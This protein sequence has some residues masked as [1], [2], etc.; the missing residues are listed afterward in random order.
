MV[1]VVLRVYCSFYSF[2]SVGPLYVVV[3]F[4]E[5]GSLVEYLRQNR[6]NKFGLWNIEKFTISLGVARGMNHLATKMVRSSH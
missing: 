4:A 2:F 6:E 3:E 5:H 1:L